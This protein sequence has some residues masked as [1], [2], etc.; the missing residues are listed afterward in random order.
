MN[1][2]KKSVF[3]LTCGAAVVLISTIALFLFDTPKY[4]NIKDFPVSVSVSSS[5][6]ISTDKTAV[7]INTASREELTALFG[8]GEKR[9]DEIVKYREKN[10]KFRSIEELTNVNGISESIVE[11]N[12]DII[13]V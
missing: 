9:A 13:T 11:K 10:G 8:V 7:N 12:S 4:N 6:E 5:E 1:I 3:I 2:N